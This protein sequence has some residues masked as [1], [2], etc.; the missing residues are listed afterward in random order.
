MNE[1]WDE[2]W[3]VMKDKVPL[4]KAIE[5]EFRELLGVVPGARVQGD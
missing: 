4:V 2:A 5:A 3:K 1:A